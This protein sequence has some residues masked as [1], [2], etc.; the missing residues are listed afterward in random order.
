MARS[1]LTAKI[2]KWTEQYQINFARYKELM[3]AYKAGQTLPVISDGEAKRLYEQNKQAGTLP[4]TTQSETVHVAEEESD[5][6]EDTSSEE[7]LDEPAKAPSPV[8]AAKKQRVGKEATKKKPAVIEPEPVLDPALRSPEKKKGGKKTSKAAEVAAEA[9]KAAAEAA[10][11][12]PKADEK[13]KKKKRK[14]G[15]TDV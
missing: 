13:Q 4:S 5:S 10:A 8:P 15:V 2:Q 9:R 6:S 11:P 14:S 12:P 3:K 7:E 1:K